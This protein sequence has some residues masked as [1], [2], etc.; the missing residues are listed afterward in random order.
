MTIELTEKE[1]LTIKNAIDQAL[2]VVEEVVN[3]GN[4]KPS[5]YEE[6][7]KAYDILEE[8]YH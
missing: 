8:K 2:P 5:V 4:E 6:L 7:E 1:Y 3:E